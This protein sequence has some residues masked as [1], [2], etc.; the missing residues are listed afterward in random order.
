MVASRFYSP[1]VF[2]ILRA[3]GALLFFGLLWIAWTSD[4]QEVG[5]DWT[6][7][8]ELTL[9]AFVL[10]GGLFGYALKYRSGAEEEALLAQMVMADLQ[11]GR[12]GEE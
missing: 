1:L 9:A 2:N 4:T 8:L 10:G 7:K 12:G 6:F 5:L 11:A 3:A